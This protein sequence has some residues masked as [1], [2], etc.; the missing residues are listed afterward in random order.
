MRA[1]RLGGRGGAKRPAAL[2]QREDAAA[3][4]DEVGEQRDGWRG[5]RHVGVIGHGGRAAGERG[6]SAAAAPGGR[7]CST[8]SCSPT[9]LSRRGPGP[10]QPC[11]WS[12][13][14]GLLRVG[15]VMPWVLRVTGFR[16]RV[17]HVHDTGSG[18]LVLLVFY[19]Y[20]DTGFMLRA[21]QCMIQGLG[22]YAQGSACA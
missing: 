6:C 7:G 8:A 19:Y 12:A 20:D 3:A 17:M 9:A 14:A 21:S 16:S 2:G 22:L 13:S 5:Q 11:P 15:T 4:V 1:A 18:L 10:H